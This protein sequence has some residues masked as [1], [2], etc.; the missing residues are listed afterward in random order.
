MARLALVMGTRRVPH[1]RG[2]LLSSADGPAPIGDRD[3]RP[4]SQVLEGE[5]NLDN[6]LLEGIDYDGTSVITRW[7]LAGF[8]GSNYSF[9]SDE[10]EDDEE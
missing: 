5:L 9:P 10:H 6:V 4:A 1:R 8:I 3:R 2:F 7:T